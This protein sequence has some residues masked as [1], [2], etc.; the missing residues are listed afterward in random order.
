MPGSVLGSEGVT[1]NKQDKNKIPALLGLT[2]FHRW[3][4]NK[5]K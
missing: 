4:E 1:V 3:A 5:T 2:Y